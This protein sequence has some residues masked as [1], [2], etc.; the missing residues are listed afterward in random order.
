MLLEA[1]G[2]S[3]EPGCLSA[4][5]V[6]Q[7]ALGLADNTVVEHRRACTA[8]AELVQTEEK[9]RAAA[10]YERV[11]SVL[12]TRMGKR[13]VWQRMQ[14]PP[15]WLFGGVAGIVA[16]GAVPLAWMHLRTPAAPPLV[17]AQ[18]SRDGRV[19][20]EDVA[21]AKVGKLR[22]GDKVRLRVLDPKALWVRLEA[23]QAGTL[24]DV[25][26]EGQKPEDGWLPAGFT[27]TPLNRMALRLM[28]C[29]QEPAIG[30]PAVPEDCFVE[31]LD[32]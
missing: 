15:R 8:C 21:P 27:V 22:P 9:Q 5:Q 28:G 11:P 6:S 29:P 25:Y 19:V 1:L 3:K 30:S 4:W 7:L 14:A 24:W 17:V 16:L 20:Q 32:L 13:N 23:Q 2:R 31:Q 26:F 12:L 18:V 10:V